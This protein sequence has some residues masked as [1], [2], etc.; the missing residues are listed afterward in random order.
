MV[1]WEIRSKKGTYVN[2]ATHEMIMKAMA[3][4]KDA[5]GTM[6]QTKM[7]AARDYSTTTFVGEVVV[8]RYE[9]V[10]NGSTGLVLV[11]PAGAVDNST[12]LGEGAV[13]IDTDLTN[14]TVTCEGFP[15][16]TP[17]ITPTPLYSATPTATPT[18]TA[19]A[20]PTRTSWP[21]ASIPPT[22]GMSTTCRSR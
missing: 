6:R 15:E 5:G 2:T 18:A 16:P 9:C 14:A 19:T 21:S 12:T 1:M 17:T 22:P 11:P 4:D 8:V 7:G 20:A 13:R 10:A 3:L